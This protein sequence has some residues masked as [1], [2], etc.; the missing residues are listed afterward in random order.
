MIYT[1]GSAKSYLDAM[2][3]SGE[4]VHKSGAGSPAGY[5]GGYA[6]KTIEDAQRRIDEY[7]DSPYQFSIFGLDADWEKD[8]VPND[9]G[10]WHN[11]TKDAPLIVLTNNG[12]LAKR[13]LMGDGE[14]RQLISSIRSEDSPV[15]ALM[16]DY[17]DSVKIGQVAGSLWNKDA[18]FRYGVEYGILIALRL[19]YG[20]STN[21]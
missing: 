7:G 1:I 20:E 10:W 17:R 8:T 11:L 12:T 9:E 18:S 14:A 6:F 21:D 16:A 4:V 2:L 5:I 13:P 3:A 19:V 15:V